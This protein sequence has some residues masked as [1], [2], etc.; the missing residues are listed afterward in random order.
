MTLTDVC[1]QAELQVP[2]FVVGAQG[3]VTGKGKTRRWKTWGYVNFVCRFTPCV[4]YSIGEVNIFRRQIGRDEHLWLEA[5]T[6]QIPRLVIRGRARHIV[7]C[8]GCWI[9]FG[10]LAIQFDQM[11]SCNAFQL[12]P[13]YN[14]CG[15]PLLVLGGLYYPYNV[16]EEYLGRTENATYHSCPWIKSINQ[17]MVINANILYIIYLYI[18]TLLNILINFNIF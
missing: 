6:V 10:S 13:I 1:Q 14:L 4:Y 15:S 5:I 16:F 8:Y 9:I 2:E 11:P 12:R 3:L 7:V 18:W 17:E